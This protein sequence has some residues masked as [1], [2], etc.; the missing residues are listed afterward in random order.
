MNNEQRDTNTFLK[1]IVIILILIALLLVA[2]IGQ[3]L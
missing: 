2:L 3:G 1:W